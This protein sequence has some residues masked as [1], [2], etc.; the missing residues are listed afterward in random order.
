MSIQIFKK[1]VPNELLFELLNNICVK[2][3]EAYIINNISFKKGMYNNLITKF[4][5]SIRKYYH[6]SK[7]KYLDKTLTYNSFITVVRQICKFNQLSYKNEIKY[8]RSTY[9]I[10]YYISE[11]EN[12]E[13]SNNLDETIVTNYS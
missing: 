5:E 2:S 4:F 7:R 11:E 8:D 9:E 10:I 12:K 1:K 13:S 3:K 6:I